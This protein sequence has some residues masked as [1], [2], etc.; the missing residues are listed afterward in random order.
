MEA[1]GKKM[2]VF[3]ALFTKHMES[4]ISTFIDE[5]VMGVKAKSVEFQ[6]NVALPMIIMISSPKHFTV[7]L[8]NG[9]ESI[10]AI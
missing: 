7:T 2:P 10:L 8:L 4:K 6:S 3:S 9:W 5:Q 1:S